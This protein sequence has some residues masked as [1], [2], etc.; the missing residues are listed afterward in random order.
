MALI[1]IVC[2]EVSEEKSFQGPAALFLTSLIKK[3][4]GLGVIG[5]TFNVVIRSQVFDRKVKGTSLQTSEH[6]KTFYYT[7]DCD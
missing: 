4:R 3:M 6:Y 7:S 2:H 5:R 1:I